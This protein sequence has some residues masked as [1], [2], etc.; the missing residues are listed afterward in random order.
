MN[1]LISHIKGIIEYMDDGL[2]IVDVNGIGYKIAISPSTMGKLPSVGKE[3]KIFTYLQVKEDGMSLYGFGSREELNMFERLISVSGIGPKGASGILSAISPSDLCLAIIAEDIKTL[4]S[5]PGIGKKTAQRMVLELKD[6]INTLEAIGGSEDQ[7]I[8]LHQSNT[9]EEA[10][11]ALVALGY[12]R[13]EAVKA[14]QS[15]FAE[16]MNV[17]EIIKNALKKLAIL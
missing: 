12:P 16:G 14:V 8:G 1:D 3:V 17:E 7:T 2:I 4:S 13:V 11:E 6:K 9:L 10:T 15:I 5:I